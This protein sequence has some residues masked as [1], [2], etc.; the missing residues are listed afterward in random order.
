MPCRAP[1]TSVDFEPPSL[2]PA[3]QYNVVDM[4]IG[5]DCPEVPFPRRSMKGQLPASRSKSRPMTPS[6]MGSNSGRSKRSSL[7]SV[8]PPRSSH[9]QAPS[10]IS[11]TR[12]EALLEQ[13]RTLVFDPGS[14]EAAISFG[15]FPLYDNDIYHRKLA[16]SMCFFPV[17]GRLLCRKAR[18]FSLNR[19]VSLGHD[20][21][22]KGGKPCTVTRYLWC[23]NGRFVCEAIGVINEHPM[24]TRQHRLLITIGGVKNALSRSHTCGLILTAAYRLPSKIKI[25]CE[26]RSLASEDGTTPLL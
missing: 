7:G 16:I 18:N 9:S 22:S 23:N 3:P 4:P 20:N 5:D 13:V 12:G 2:V 19:R 17:A 24:V 26:V 10:S 6:S 21:K 14:A 25:P 11:K 8:S 15:I 1:S